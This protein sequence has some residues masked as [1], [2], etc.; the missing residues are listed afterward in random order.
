MEENRERRCCD[1]RNALQRHTAALD[2]YFEN[3]N[4][5]RPFIIAVHSQG[6][7]I[8]LLVLKKYFREHRRQEER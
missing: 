2:Y 1:F 8:A 7:M 6:S 3:C 5:G 4:N